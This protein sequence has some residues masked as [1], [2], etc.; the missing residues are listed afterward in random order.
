MKNILVTGGTG[1]IGSHLIGRLV[2]VGYRVRVLTSSIPTPTTYDWLQGVA[3]VEWVHGR[4]NDGALMEKL[5]RGVDTVVH[6]AWT[7]VPAEASINPAYDLETNVLGGLRLLDACVHNGV[8]RVIF[9]SSGGAVY[10]IPQC[11]PVSEEHPLL[12]FSFYGIAKATFEK[13][14]HFYA[15][16]RELSSLVFRI[17]NVYGERQNLTKNQGVIGIWLQRIRQGLPI[18][19]WGDGSVIRDYVYVED[20]AEALAAGLD[21]QGSHSIFNL[22]YGQGFSLNELLDAIEQVIGFRPQVEY[23]PARSFDVPANV[24]NT[25]RIQQELNWTATIGLQEGIRRTW[26]WLQGA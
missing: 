1:L 2:S 24:L 13:Y 18:Q 15:L 17:S 4:F 12:P 8:Q 10:G 16:K 25:Q 5:L 20:V 6:L 19:I 7:T 26:A 21:Y 3:A 22:G 11:L 14:L 9:A 23:L